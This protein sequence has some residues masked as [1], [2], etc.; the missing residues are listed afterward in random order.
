M[1]W[2]CNRVIETGGT[3]IADFICPTPDTRTA[4]GPAF[5]VWVDRIQEGRFVDTNRI[6]VAPDKFDVRVTADGTPL[7]WAEKIVGGLRPP[8]NPQRP[9]A[10]FIGRYQPFHP[11]HRRLIEE[12]L[13]RIGQVC[14]AV[15]DTHGVDTKNPLSFFDV[16]QRIEAGLS[17]Y[18][19]RFVVVPLP[20]ITHVLYGRDVGYAVERIDLD[21]DIEAISATDIR[22]QISKS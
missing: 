15:R 7:H 18:T 11:G 16:K 10:L 5:T 22:L 2:L 13:R 4:F 9:T 6:F 12:G 17:A 14:I 20:N 21:A 1:G 19:G 8:F 3:A